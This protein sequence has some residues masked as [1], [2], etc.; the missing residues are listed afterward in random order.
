[1][2]FGTQFRP[3]FDVTAMMDNKRCANRCSTS[4]AAQ[5]G[6]ETDVRMFGR[7]SAAHIHV[8]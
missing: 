2:A 1:M 8:G 4:Q 7:A 5:S 3:S 6:T